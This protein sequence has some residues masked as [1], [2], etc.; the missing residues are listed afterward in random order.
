MLHERDCLVAG[1]YIKGSTSTLVAS[2]G[3]NFNLTAAADSTIRSTGGNVT[4]NAGRAY[5]Q[6]GS[7]VL[8]PGG[9]IN[10]TAQQ[11]DINEARETGSQST[12]QKF[13]QSGLTV[14][15]TSPVL[16]AVQTAASQINA[17]GNTSS[18]RM[19]ALAAANA[20]FNLKQGADAIK[21]GQ[22]DA[23]GQVPTGNKNPDGTP[24]TVQGNA[25]DKAGGI[26]IS[27]SLGA[28]SSQSKHQRSADSAKG[29]NLNAGG[30]VTIQA[31]GAGAN[32]DIT[33]Q[34]S[35]VQAGQATTL[36]AD[37][38]VN[39][40]AAQNTTQESSNS[41]NSSGSIGVGI[42]L[43]AGGAKAGVTVSAS[44]G[45]GQGA[46]N[47]TTYTNSQVVGN[48]VNIQSGGDTNILGGVIKGDQVTV[49]KYVT[50]KALDGLYLMIGEEEKK[51]RQDPVG[52][53][54]ALL[55]KVFGALKP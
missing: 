17:A 20:A 2:V 38:Q 21:A 15:I 48:T 16:S 54:S 44:A 51:I 52:T 23:N 13:K 34:G 1:L 14:A 27:L 22:D 29:S 32:S 4:I 42:Q 35:K 12:E 28:S 40:V 37:D 39:I 47:S 36:K 49:E 53:G 10:I 19:Q 55:Q 8:T 30:N 41:T 46:G 18:G 50:A 7:D 33:I 25:A 3:R 26:G 11:V 43:G 31:T 45:N 6:T 24:E 5:T 9:D